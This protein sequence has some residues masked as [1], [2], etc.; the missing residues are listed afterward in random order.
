ME[1]QADSIFANSQ[2]IELYDQELWQSITNDETSLDL[3]IAC[4][5][6]NVRGCPW[7]CPEL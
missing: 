6:G 5:E 7:Q 4:D 1:S 2:T 3:A